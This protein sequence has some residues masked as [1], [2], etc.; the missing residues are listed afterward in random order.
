MNKYKVTDQVLVNAP[1]E[2]V[3]KLITNPI[4]IRLWDELP[5]NYVGGNFQLHSVIEWQGHSKLTVTE[6]IE[7]KQLRLSL[8]LPKVDIDPLKYTISYNYVLTDYKGATFLKF[9][10]GEFSPLPNAQKYLES[11]LEFI[12]KS[13]E[14]IKQLAENPEIL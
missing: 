4:Y 3:W 12:I 13:K 1:K 2:K 9:E 5:E 11:A 10:I 6:Y 8:Y 7:F 14:K